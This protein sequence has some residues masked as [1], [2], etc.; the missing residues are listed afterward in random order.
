MV[1]QQSPKLLFQVRL[2]ADLPTL[3]IGENGR[4]RGTIETE[5]ENL[6][7]DISKKQE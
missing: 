5:A 6:L 3:K 7:R 4:L 2:L 1:S